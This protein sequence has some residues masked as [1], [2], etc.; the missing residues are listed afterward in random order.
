M[1]SSKIEGIPSYIV[2]AVTLLVQSFTRMV[3]SASIIENSEA[4]T[5]MY[6]LILGAQ[7][8]HV[9]LPGG[10]PDMSPEGELEDVRLMAPDQFKADRATFAAERRAFFAK[11]SNRQVRSIGV[12]LGS[13]HTHTR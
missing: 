3:S 8:V 11:E 13:C 1:F 5:V 2:S 10:A 12:G 9:S 6:P 4:P 7:A